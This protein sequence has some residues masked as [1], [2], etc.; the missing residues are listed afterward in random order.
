MQAIDTISLTINRQKVMVDK[1]TTVLEAANASG[2]YIPTLCYH[3]DLTPFG[4]CRLCMVEIE[5]MRGFPTACTTPATDGMIVQT[6]T[7]QLQELRR[8]IQELI[9]T[10]HPHPCLT[11]NRRE[12][13][14]P[15]SICLRNVAV[16]ERCVLCPK[17]GQCELQR[18]ADYIGISEVSLPYS[19]KCLP[20]LRDNPFFE[21]DYNLCILCGRCI[22]ACQE[23]RGINAIAFTY[24]G[25]KALVG[26]AFD[27]DLKDSGCKFCFACVEVCP[28]GAIMDK[29][30]KYKPVKDKEAHVVPCRNE[31]PA[32]IDVARYVRLIA[33]G[34]PA[35]AL[36]VIREKVPFPAS[37]G[38]VCIHPCETGCRRGALNDPIAIKFLKRYAADHDD[39]KWLQNSKKAPSTGK[40]VAVVGSGPAGLTAAYY[41]AKQGHSVTVFE[42][43]PKAGGMMRVG[44]PDYRLPQEVLDAEIKV[45]TDA[46]VEIK[47]STRVEST[48]KLLEEG[49]DSVFIGVGAHQGMTMGIEGEDS[50]DV[51]DCAY[52]LREINLGGKVKLGNRVVVVGG[53]NAAIDAARV[54]L[55]SGAKEVTIAYRRTRA[56]MPA[57]P[58]EVEDALHENVEIMF[59]VAPNRVTTE[60]GANKMECIRMELGE[61]DA[62]G[63]RR[64][65]P[66]EGSEFTLEFDTLI[67]AIGQRPEIPSGFNLKTDRGNTLKV[68]SGTLVTSKEGIFAGGDAVTGPASVIEAI[69]AGR[70]AAISMD[71]YLGGNGTIDEILVPVEKANPY[72][73]IE[74]GFADRVRAEMP[75]LAVEKRV[76]N[77]T[78]VEFGYS[79]ETAAK[80]ADRCLR[81]DLRLQIHPV[82]LPP[83][84]AE[85]SKQP[86]C[87]EC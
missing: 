32:H 11:C 47:T 48:A 2:I 42:A 30:E 37:L 55:R 31:C 7:S 44:I 8:N 34:K 52:F 64:P 19:N 70:Q 51:M 28:T 43:L 20:I 23:L 83:T 4:G 41:L 59:L 1:G 72:L 58:E 79:E 17:N 84:K 15:L 29:A 77:F 22:R 76:N 49:Y 10:E 56:E 5:G 33:E 35:E 87:I 82:I 68:D 26:T 36:A 66:I 80:E 73:G 75:M 16:T 60:N 27:R 18:V 12:R 85:L 54:A 53:G 6:N 57:S 63:R 62:S 38:R 25:S 69:A 3:P 21:R 40:R 65:V 45:I 24:R 9:L 14:G 78:E 46:G 50:P 81:C 71:R 13:C 39:G 61:P 67:A 74:D 86:S